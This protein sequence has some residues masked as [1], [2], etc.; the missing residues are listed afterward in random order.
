ALA[1]SSALPPIGFAIDGAQV[2]I[3]DD[4]L[5]PVAPG[6]IGEICISGQGVGRGYHN[7]PELTAKVFAADP[8]GALGRLYRTGDRGRFL[9]DGQ[10]E[11]LGRIDDQ[12]KLR[13]YRI[14]PGEIVA[15]LCQH[16]DVLAGA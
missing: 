9:P 3:R 8:D 7:R 1:H 2:T 4:A 13:G 15:A 5:Q 10:I 14:E 12:I 11:F 6:E 16:P